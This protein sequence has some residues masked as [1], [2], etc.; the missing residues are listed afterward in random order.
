MNPSRN[1]LQ[2]HALDYWQIIRNRI[3]LI[4]LSFLLVFAVAAIITYI[5]PRKYR[6]RVEMV[7]ERNAD[8]LRVQG[9]QQDYISTFG[10]NFL[11]TQFEIITKRKTLDRVVDKLD[12]VKRWG[13]P[14][15]QFAAMK[16][17]GNVDAQSSIK[18]DFIS[19][20][21]F[22]E[23][24]EMA[25]EIANAISA[26]YSETRLEV[27]N[28]RTDNGVKELDVQ[29]AAKEQ[30]TRQA[31]DK[32]IHIKKQLGI[33][34]IP[35]YGGMRAAGQEDIQSLDNSTLLD[36]AHDI[37]K[38]RRDISDMTAQIEQ[39]KTLEGD[40]LIRQAGELRVE[41]DTI[42]KL[43]PIYQ[44]LL[45]QRQAKSSSGLGTNHPTIKAIV[46]NIDQT[47][48]LL[49]EAAE[50]YRKNLSFRLATAQKQFAEVERLNLEQRNKSINS[51][52]DNQEFLA[53]KREWDIL[54]SETAKLKDTKAQK[55][56][57]KQMH[58]TPV[59]VYQAAEPEMRPFKP[60][61]NLNLALG[62]VIG[63][64]F[65]FGVAFFLEYLDTSV[66][67]MDDVEGFLGVP[68]LAVIP[69]GVGILH[70][71]SGANPDA[72]AY[73]ILR[74]NIE[75]NRK[76]PD[77]NCISV[78]SGGAGE[79]KST[80][81]VNLASVCVQAGYT[82]LVIDADMR[83]PRMHTFFDVP[84][85]VGLSTFLSTDIPLAEVVVRT[86]VD[87]LYFMPSGIM[88]ADPSGLLNSTKF[89]A[90]IEDVKN[91]FDVVL[92]D[93]PPILGVSDASV[94]C[95]VADLT[96]IVVQHR[97]LPR[98]MLMR[99]KQ[100]V[101]NVGG[102]VLGVVL[103]NVDLQ[104]DKSYQYATNYYGY[105]ADAEKA[106]V[107]AKTKRKRRSTED[108]SI[109]ATSTSSAHASESTTADVF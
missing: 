97:K 8:D 108:K 63:L 91:R 87:N 32:M 11:K 3:G 9:H 31:L 104:S 34:E 15:K 75:F 37:Y 27:D 7:I 16:L 33:V 1:E 101:E 72:E 105:Y 40:D 70:R 99:V 107:G 42:R 76:T 38:L 103:N 48:K 47:R 22:D 19:I 109:A 36:G 85:T 10:D 67:S 102:T 78:V 74:T 17:L 54:S 60:N 86:P 2:R 69:R 66:K 81:M 77:Q 44:D 41:N 5:M 73:R 62:A 106:A 28:Q 50:D 30:Q 59:T 53:A 88:T 12:L 46:A 21:Y 92:I 25:A 61:V 95:S 51:Q 83:R 6:G 64:M 68:V 35:S 100:S 79:G 39:L 45:L 98:Q 80:T 96:M 93:S 65:G 52:A 13:L 14:S 24:P 90:L 49:L 29:I 82:T 56:I 18:S 26:S 89:N 23:D 71:T 94:L 55:E 84:H 57:D 43:G 58:K 20:E 4:L